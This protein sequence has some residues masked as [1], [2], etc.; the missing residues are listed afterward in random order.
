MPG[1]GTF[2]R[3]MALAIAILCPLGHHAAA[4][5]IDLKLFAAAEIDRSKGCSV[6]LWQADRHPDRD[7]FAIAFFEPLQGPDNIRQPARIK[8]GGDVITLR[9]V[10]ASGKSPG[11]GVTP[12]QRYAMP[13]DGNFVDLAL[14][15]G[16]LEGEAIAIESGTMTV[17][18]RGKP[19]FRMQ[20]KGGAGCMTPAAPAPSQAAGGLFKRYDVRP[21]HVPRG[22]T[23]AIQTKYKCDADMMKTG[24][25]GFQ[26]SEESALWEIPCERFAYQASAV[27]A[28]VYLPNPAQNPEF[29]GFQ[30]PKSHKRTNPP[31]VL[32]NPEW[33]A[34][35]RTVTSIALGRGIGDCGVLERHRVDET[36]HFTL[37]EYREKPN[38]DG[39]T[40]KPEDW[41]LV[42]RAK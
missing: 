6:A 39:K 20:V 15:L 12:N 41:P 8:I 14:R 4:E 25:I 40:G 1:F 21:A 17:I 26:M 22:F 34:K 31:G 10:S 42:F 32:L 30:Q 36:G 29:L 9:R 33:N 2:T 35:T 7:K 5:A 27:Y 23:Q 18:M 11:Y 3:L 13:A 24:I 37:A 16:A 19:D 28:L 38:C